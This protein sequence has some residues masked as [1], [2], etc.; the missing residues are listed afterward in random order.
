MGMLAYGEERLTMKRFTR[1]QFLLGAAGATLAAC[2]PRA[3]TS[4]PSGSAPS[5]AS[6][7]PKPDLPKPPG[8]ILVTPGD[9]LYEQTYS[10]IARLD[11]ADW[12]L[13]INGMVDKPLTL[14]YDDI[15]SMPKVVELRTLECI[16]NPVGGN[17]IG[18]VNWG[19]VYLKDVMQGMQVQDGARRA[20]FSAADGYYTSVTL[21]WIIQPG[22]LL[23]YEINGKPLTPEHGY[24][25][26]ILMPGL[27]GQ[28]M[29]KWITHIEFVD[30]DD[31]GYWEKQG[32]SDVASVQTNS[33]FD[34][35]VNGASLPAGSVP[36]Y[37]VAFAGKRDITQVEVR[38]DDGEWQ[39]AELLQGDSS[40]VW[41]QWAFD[42]QAAP[43]NHEL[44]VRA[45][46][47][48]GFTQEV[49][50]SGTLSRAY[51]NGTDLI[52]SISVRVA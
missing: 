13:T 28:K 16:G 37:G 9:K 27:Y 52:H 10:E 4:Q 47:S 14:S 21:D 39:A 15:L 46:D 49:F 19:G 1:R 20:R 40:L 36:V 43:G 8:E 48:D 51:P 42:W 23:A 17:L 24:P 32:W 38:I 18:N 6:S 22:T 5:D 33:Q 31:L 29:P 35:P 34:Y 44:L 3:T 50:A 26:R 41:T 12:T 25:L 2:G 45:T 11:A 30:T 7:Q